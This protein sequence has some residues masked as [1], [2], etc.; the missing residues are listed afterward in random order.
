MRHQVGNQEYAARTEASIN[1]CEYRRPFVVT[2]QMVEH[3]GSHHHV[4]RACIQNCFANIGVEGRDGKVP[5]RPD[6]FASTIEHR[7]AQVD[8]GY[9]IEEWKHIEKS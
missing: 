3:G 8:E 7:Q 1:L 5:F 4:E 9:G 2:P 6:A